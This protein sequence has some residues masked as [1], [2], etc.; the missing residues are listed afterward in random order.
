MFFYSSGP[1]LKCGQSRVLYENCQRIA[2]VGLGDIEDKNSEIEE[3]DSKKESIRSGIGAGVKALTKFDEIDEILV[4]SCGD[5]EAASEGA[6]LSQ[7]K[8][9]ELKKKKDEDRKEFPAL[10]PLEKERDDEWNC[11]KI[12]A[13]G[14]NIA[15]T[16]ME[17][18]AN[19]MTP[20]LFAEVIN[21]INALSLSQIYLFL[22]YIVYYSLFYI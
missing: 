1:I 18:P 3:I 19:Y 17:T 9:D 10:K 14:Q 13:R 2:V 8:Y 12:K 6:F 4:D 15:R 7:W 11:G 20:T 21:F 22:F 16:L 5:N